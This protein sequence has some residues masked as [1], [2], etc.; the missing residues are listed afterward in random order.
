MPVLS[1]RAD[2]TSGGAQNVNGV[3][4]MTEPSAV[5][6]AAREVAAKPAEKAHE[7]HV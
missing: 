6:D 5:Y 1:K 4:V 2:T 7:G 3:D